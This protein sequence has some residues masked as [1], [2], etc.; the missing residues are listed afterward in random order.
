MVGR[1]TLNLVIGVRV[2]VP[3]QVLNNTTVIVLLP[4]MTIDSEPDFEH[5]FGKDIEVEDDFDVI[6]EANIP[7]NV[8]L[9]EEDGKW[10]L[11]ADGYMPRK[12]LEQGGYRLVS[13]S[14]EP[15]RALIRD[16]VIPL[17]RNA[18]ANLETV[19]EQGE[20]SLYYWS[21]PETASPEA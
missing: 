8:T 17:Y 12:W 6:D 21:P 18:I 9:T 4:A 19:N 13:D 11:E 16:R 7:V 5:P 2:P 3:E 10:V 1:Q 20:T 15:L 14:P